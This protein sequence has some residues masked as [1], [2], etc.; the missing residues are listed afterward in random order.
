MD[1]IV[2]GKKPTKEYVYINKD[3]KLYKR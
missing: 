1:F 2:A 3:G